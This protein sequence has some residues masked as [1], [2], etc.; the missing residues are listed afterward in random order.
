[1]PRATHEYPFEQIVAAG[2]SARVDGLL[3]FA[4]P[5][6]SYLLVLDDDGSL[7]VSVHPMHI[8]PKQRLESTKAS[9]KSFVFYDPLEDG[10]EYIW[11]QWHQIDLPTME[12]LI[13]GTF[14]ARDFISSRSGKAIDYPEIWSVMF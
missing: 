13:G 10:M 9:G 5:A 3:D 2:I 1:M 14:D 6:A 7:A 8:Y 11:L 4:G 12:H